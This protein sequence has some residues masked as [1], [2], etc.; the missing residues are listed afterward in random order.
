MTKLT[1]AGARRE[2]ERRAT[3]KQTKRAAKAAGKAHQPIVAAS[4]EWLR[5]TGK[6][7]REMAT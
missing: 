2:L 7:L 5:F 6:E 1:K 4:S 3:N